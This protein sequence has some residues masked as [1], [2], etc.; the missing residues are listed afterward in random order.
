MLTCRNTASVKI[1]DDVSAL[2]SACV[3]LCG[4]GRQMARDKPASL[5]VTK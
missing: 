4:G 5:R 1:V 3:V 2:L